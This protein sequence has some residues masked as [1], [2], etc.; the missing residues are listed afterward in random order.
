[1]SASRNTEYPEVLFCETDSGVILE[2][3]VEKYTEITGREL[4][5]ADPVLLFIKWM[6]AAV[7]MINININESARQ[8]VPRYADGEFLDSLGE[9]FFNVKRLEGT[10]AETVLRFTIS[11]AQSENIVIE[12]GTRAKNGDKVFATVEDAVILAGETQV[13]VTARAEE[14]G[15]KYNGIAVGDINVIVDPF[16]YFAAVSN[17]SVTSGGVDVES[18]ESYYKRM[19]ESLEGYS[20]AGAIG[21]YKY[22]AES[23]DARIAD[24]SVTSPSA[25]RVN[26]KVLLK[27]GELP[28]EAVLDIVESAVN[29]DDVRPL[30]DLVSVQA[31]SAVSYDVE[32]TYYTPENSSQSTS[33]TA[34]AVNA[35]VTEYIAWQYAKMGRDINPSRLIS[36]IM[37]AADIKRVVVTKPVYTVVG[38]GAAAIADDVNITFGGAESE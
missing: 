36:M 27:D 18:D 21:G 38:E 29:A 8:N 14:T 26:I 3:L 31:A 34:A 15:V 10:A 11:A 24:V 19:R 6:A 4:E 13:D 35:A 32:L 7:S 5:S 22:Y 9:L 33:E 16:A 17:V 25:G 1:M 37:A 30:T 20:T 28:D 23:C 2:E 12:A